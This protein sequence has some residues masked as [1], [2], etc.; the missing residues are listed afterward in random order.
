[1][2]LPRFNHS[3]LLLASTIVILLTHC[4]GEDH[5]S[6]ENEPA[7]VEPL[8]FEQREDTGIDF[9]NNLVPSAEWNILT[10]LYYYLSLIHI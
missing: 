3:K 8:L 7:E 10:Y 4:A 6:S 5:A 2:F 1:M 9:A